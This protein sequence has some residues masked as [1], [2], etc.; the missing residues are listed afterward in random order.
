[1]HAFFDPKDGSPKV[2]IEISGTSV[3]TKKSITALLDTGHNRSL[4]LPIFDLIEI[5]A[6]ISSYGEVTYASGN[7]AVNYY[8]SVNVTVDNK[9]EEVQA[10]MIENPAANE[11]IAGLELFAPYVAIIDFKNQYVIFESEENIRKF[12]ANKEKE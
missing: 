1:M 5:G 7:T 6:K 9:T 4:S 2:I 12:A 3:N 8:F 10:S 11:A